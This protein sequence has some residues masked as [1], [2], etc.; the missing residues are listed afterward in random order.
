MESFLL[1]RR[2][3]GKSPL[4]AKMGMGPRKNHHL[5]IYRPRIGDA[6]RPCSS[7]GWGA[8]L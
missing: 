1:T 8:R 7:L 5:M 6:S 4:S 3:S 2:E